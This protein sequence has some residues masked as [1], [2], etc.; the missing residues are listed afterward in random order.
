MILFFFTPS[1]SESQVLAVKPD[2]EEKSQGNRC[3]AVWREASPDWRRMG[4]IP[5][6][7]GSRAKIALMG[8]PVHKSGC[9]VLLQ[10]S[11]KMQY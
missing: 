1:I 9:G 4:R 10:S 6:G 3:A 7:E 5:G 2:G 11:G 8:L